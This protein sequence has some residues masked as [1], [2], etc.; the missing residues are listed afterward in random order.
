M[1]DEDAALVPDLL[2]ERGNAKDYARLERKLQS[3]ET[4]LA[5]SYRDIESLRQ[6]LMESDDV[7][8][9]STKII[10]HLSRGPL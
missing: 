9:A 4:A 5:A 3:T 6:R 2:P 7:I 10:A 8:R 1:A